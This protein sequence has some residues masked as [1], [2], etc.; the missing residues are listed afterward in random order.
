MHR[1]LDKA[2]ANRAN[3]S[4]NEVVHQSDAVFIIIN[5]NVVNRLDKLVPV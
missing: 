3:P 2:L 1:D 5:K 4:I